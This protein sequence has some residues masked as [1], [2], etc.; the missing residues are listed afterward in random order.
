MGR[1]SVKYICK[2][3]YSNY[4]LILAYVYKKDF[5]TGKYIKRIWEN[6]KLPFRKDYCFSQLMYL[7]A[8][9]KFRNVI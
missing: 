1:E 8:Q 9:E 4:R 5:S 7:Y 3:V 6:Q 2:I